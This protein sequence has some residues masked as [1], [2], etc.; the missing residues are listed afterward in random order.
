[1]DQILTAGGQQLSRAAHG[2]DVM[3][4]QHRGRFTQTVL[5]HLGGFELGIIF[6]PLILPVQ[7]QAAQPDQ[8]GPQAK[9][10]SCGNSV[11]ARQQGGLALHSAAAQGALNQFQGTHPHPGGGR[12]R[13]SPARRALRVRGHRGQRGRGGRRRDQGKGPESCASEPP[14]RLLSK[15]LP[16]PRQQ[17]QVEKGEAVPKRVQTDAGRQSPGLPAQ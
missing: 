1:M 5:E 12:L 11:Q 6:R 2:A 15:D 3:L 4:L 14:R 9:Q 8:R 13:R 7:G 17:E 16:S 10:R